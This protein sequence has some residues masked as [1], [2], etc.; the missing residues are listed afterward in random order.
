MKSDMETTATPSE[1]LCSI[2]NPFSPL[3]ATMNYDKYDKKIFEIFYGTCQL[4][5]IQT[6]KNW[7]VC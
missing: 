7:N 3:E 4:Y 1:G 5:K 6:N 2:V